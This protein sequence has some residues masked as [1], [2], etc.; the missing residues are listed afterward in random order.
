M[1]VYIVSRDYD[2]HHLFTVG[3]YK[4]DGSW[5]AESD[6]REKNSAAERVAY[7]NGNSYWRHRP[8]KA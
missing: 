8:P 3:F 1:Y 4:P 6:H 7:L 2:D 5:E